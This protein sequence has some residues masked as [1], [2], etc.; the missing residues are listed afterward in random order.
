MSSSVAIEERMTKAL[1]ALLKEYS[2][3]RTSRATPTLLENIRVESYG[4]MMALSAVASVT[5]QD[6]RTLLV[7][8]WDAG[9]AKAVDAAIRMSELSLNPRVDG[10]KLFVSLPELTAER[11]AE[12]VKL[13][14]K[15]SEDMKVS[16][17]NFRREA[18]EAVKAREKNKEISE[19]ELK[20]EMDAIQKITDAYIE[21]VDSAATNKQK[22]ITSI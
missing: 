21:K 22:E 1:E 2:G 7:T 5:V 15:K 3:L 6:V 13:I 20:L 8:V 17:R 12:I 9:N 16:M 18:N 19:D 4:Q 14:K 10:N 11:R